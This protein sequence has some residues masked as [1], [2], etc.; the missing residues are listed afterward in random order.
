M[1]SLTK[2]LP[3]QSTKQLL[4]KQRLDGNHSETF[5]S[6]HALS[7]WDIVA[8]RGRYADCPR[9]PNQSERLCVFLWLDH[10][11][12]AGQ[13]CSFDYTQGR[14]WTLNELVTGR[15]WKYQIILN[16]WGQRSRG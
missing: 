14:E 10:L 15:F 4:R 11:H 12:V 6:L 1:N 7:P 8:D 3:Q 13:I 9:E 16:T 2:V 5:L